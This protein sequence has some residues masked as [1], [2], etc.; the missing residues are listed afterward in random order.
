M[1]VL[2]VLEHVFDPIGLLDNAARV[3]APGGT[4]VTITP[5]VWPLHNYPADCG[6]LMPDWYRKYATSRG[7]ALLREWFWYVGV[8][9][10]AA[11]RTPDGQDHFPPPASHRPSFRLYSRLVH[12]LFNTYGRGMMQ[13]SHIAIGAVL[14]L[15]EPPAPSTTNRISPQS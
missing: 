15:P 12:R 11:Y 7:V 4:V 13:P 14:A 8:G 10:I 3:A 2:N 5:A 1:L 9:P 6:R